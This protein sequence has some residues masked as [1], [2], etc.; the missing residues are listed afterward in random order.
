MRLAR[1]FAR[2]PADIV[3]RQLPRPAGACAVAE[4]YGQTTGIA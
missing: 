2:Q 4:A 3:S 1:R